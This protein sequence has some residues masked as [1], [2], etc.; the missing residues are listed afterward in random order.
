MSVHPQAHPLEYLMVIVELL[1]KPLTYQKKD[2][3]PF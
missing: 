2:V 3:T 1:P